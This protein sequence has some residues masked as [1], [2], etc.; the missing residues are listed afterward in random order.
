MEVSELYYGFCKNFITLG[1]N[2]SDI[3]P[4]PSTWKYRIYSYFDNLGRYLGYEVV[5]EDT[6]TKNDG[7]EN[8]A[9]K[10][11]DMT[12]RS[13]DDSK[14]ILALEYENERNIDNDIMKLAA[15]DCLRVLIMYRYQNNGLTDEEVID[16]VVTENKKYKRDD[17]KYLIM[18]LPEY[19]NYK[20]PFNKLKGLLLDYDGDI[21]GSGSAIGYTGED[22]TL[23]FRNITWKYL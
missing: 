3:K 23:A 22:G 16:K 7:I 11:L 4:T 21:R 20:K 10:R 12:W 15:M 17:K 19:F 2:Y 5:T 1:I 8:L 13:P 9:G 6:Y 14:Y 18:I